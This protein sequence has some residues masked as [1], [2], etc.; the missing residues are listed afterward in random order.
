MTANGLYDICVIG[1]KVDRY[2]SALYASVILHAVCSHKDLNQ[3]GKTRSFLTEH[4]FGEQKIARIRAVKDFEVT[5]E[6]A[7]LFLL[8]NGSRR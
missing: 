5:V 8:P 3:L 6:Q 7:S 1:T 4:T 2:S